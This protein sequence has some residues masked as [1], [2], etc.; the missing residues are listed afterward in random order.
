VTGVTVI[1]PHNRWVWAFGAIVFT[2][3]T[4]CCLGIGADGGW[5]WLVAGAF[6]LFSGWIALQTWRQALRPR[7]LMRLDPEGVECAEGRLAWDDVQQVLAVWKRVRDQDRVWLLFVGRAGTERLPPA[8]RYFASLGVRGLFS[9]A[10]DL[11]LPATALPVLVVNVSASMSRAQEALRH[12]Y[13]QPVP[14][15]PESAL[16]AALAAL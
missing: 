14:T 10:W 15:I 9:A 3:L 4:V 16:M 12:Y 11:R 2:V 5:T 8:G 7:P 1:Y 13:A 6:V